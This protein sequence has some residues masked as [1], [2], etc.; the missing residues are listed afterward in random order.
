M[1]IQEIL[2]QIKIKEKN[3]ITNFYYFIKMTVKA[4]I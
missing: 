2:H 3:K 1:D 4:V